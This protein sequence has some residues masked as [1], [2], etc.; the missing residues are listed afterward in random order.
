MHRKRI[1]YILHDIQIGGVEIALISAIPELNRQFDL[2]VIALGKIDDKVISNLT[3]DEKRRLYSFDYKFYLYPWLIFKLLQFV[4]Q[5]DPAIMICS[6]W[7]ASLVG[8][9][10]KAFRK[11][12]QF[13]AFIHNTGFA[14]QFDRFFTILAIRH[15]DRI[16][17]DSKA[18]F[19]FVNSTFK[20]NV[21]LQ[22]ISFCIRP[23]PA[24]AHFIQLDTNDVRIFF[25]GRIAAVK[26]LPLAI[27]TI[28]YLRSQNLNVTLDIYGRNDGAEEDVKKYIHL[29]KLSDHIK[30][31]GELHGSK[32]EIMNQYNFLIQ[33]SSREGMA[34]SVVEAMQNGILCIVS[35]VGEI[36]NYASDME[37][38]IFID[39][40]E[41]KQWLPSLEKIVQVLRN[42]ALYDQMC[43][44]SVDKFKNAQTYS[45]SLIEQLN[46]I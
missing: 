34:M 7:R 33:L 13:L 22:I 35:P 19:D 28:E 6:L 40:W 5:F 36:P 11:R 30:F 43:R 21:P 39:I 8:V 41:S 45:E 32:T 4:L 37:T 27:D 46:T 29:K 17:T 25:L 20:P 16:L 26:N 24:E 42:P 31:M 2:R 23:S 1:L 44:N 14:H 9:V 3:P 10:V 15:S 18:T 12:I 38:A